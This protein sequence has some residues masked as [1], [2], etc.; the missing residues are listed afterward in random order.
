MVP[1]NPP[2]VTVIIITTPLRN[3]IGTVPHVMVKLGR[4]G[5]YTVKTGSLGCQAK[6]H[7]L[8]V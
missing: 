3:G 4:T 6:I 7:I 1:A 2:P 5:H 8:K